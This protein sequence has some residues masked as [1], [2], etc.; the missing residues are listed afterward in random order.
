[1][2]RRG[3]FGQAAGL[4]VRGSSRVQFPKGLM[5]SRYF[6]FSL[7]VVGGGGKNFQSENV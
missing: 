1:M 2:G 3:T 4:R 7:Q 5:D 6:F